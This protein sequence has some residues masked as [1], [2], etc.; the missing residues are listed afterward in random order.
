MILYQIL[1]N[2]FHFIYNKKRNQCL[3]TDSLNLIKHRSH[4]ATSFSQKICYRDLNSS[5]ELFVL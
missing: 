2:K 4:L 1:F 5:E 3:N